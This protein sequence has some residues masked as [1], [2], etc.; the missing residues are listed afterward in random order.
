MS[1][2]LSFIGFILPPLIDV[3]NRYIKNS[4]LRFWVSILVCLIIGSGVSLLLGEFTIDNA[5]EQ[6]LIYIAQAQ[7]SYRLWSETGARKDLGL[8]GG[9]K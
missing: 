7:I 6:A 5:L 8:V 4:D 3:I 1:N 2:V 9:S